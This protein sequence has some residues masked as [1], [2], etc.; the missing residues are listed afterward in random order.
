[1]RGKHADSAV[2]VTGN[3]PLV[4]VLNKALENSYRA[5][6]NRSSTWTPTGYHRKDAHLVSA[7]ATFK[8]VKAH[9]FLGERGTTHQQED[10]RVLV[11]DEAQRTY[12]KGRR[13][14]GHALEDHEA[15]L[16]LQAQRKSFS[17]GGAVVV[18][19]IGHNQA[20]N[21]GERGMIAWLDAAERFGWTF[22][23]SDETLSLTELEEKE[24]WSSHVLRRPLSHGHLHQSMRYYRN[25][26]LENWVSCVL[27]NDFNGA[28]KLMVTM[29]AHGNSIWLTRDLQR[30]KAWVR[31]QAIGGQRAGLIASGQAKRLAAEGLFV[32]LK[33]DIAN[34]MLTA[35][36]DVRSSNALETVQNQYQVQGLEL[37]YCIVCWDADLRRQDT[38]WKS[39]KMSGSDWQSDN[40]LDVAKNGYRVLLTRSRKGMVVFVPKGDA[41]GNDRTRAPAFYDQTFEYLKA[42]GAKEM[43]T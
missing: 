17:Q 21:R 7:A 1:M 28:Q 22:S 5:Q 9:N 12:E 20:I 38:E 25:T 29:T 35:S 13:V 16:I 43:D 40:L 31:G 6:G 18:A 15:D 42:C 34:W 27:D 3:A 32:E 2:F 14:L 41:S 39:F 26:V 23:I 10:G 30:A 19:L 36:T 8:V 24:R 33:P 11:F 4:D 37:D